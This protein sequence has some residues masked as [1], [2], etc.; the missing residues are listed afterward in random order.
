MPKTKVLLVGESWVSAATHY[1]G[2]DAFGSVTFHKGAE[3]LAEALRDSAFDLTYMTAHEAAEGFPFTLEGLSD[4]RAILLSD[5]GANTLLLPQSVWLHGRPTPNRLKL[6]RDWTAAGGGLVMI[7][8]YLT[9][10]GFD[11]RGRWHRTPVEAALPVT[12]LPYDDRIEAPEGFRPEIT[13]PA[14]HPILRGLEGEWPLLLG[15]NEVMAREREDV[16]ILARL[17]AEQG[18]HPLLVT[19][20]HGEGRTLAW[21]SD[22][23]PHWLPEDFVRWPG[24]AT[25]WRNVLSWVTG[26]R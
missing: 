26:A 16:Q 22:I 12:C 13:G 15:A 9:F 25:L 1:K 5:I 20:R 21:T 10:Q 17:P 7:G 4:Y 23:G 18:G 6:I 14:D 19:G 3:P 8:G 11:G 24:Y 2:F